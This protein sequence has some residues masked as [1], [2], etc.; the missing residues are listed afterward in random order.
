MVL[1]NIKQIFKNYTTTSIWP[2]IEQLI[3]QAHGIFLQILSHYSACVTFGEFYPLIA[4]LLSHV[5]VHILLYSLDN[6]YNIIP[7]F[8]IKGFVFLS[9]FIF[10]AICRSLEGCNIVAS[11]VMVGDTYVSI[12][13]VIGTTTSY[14][15]Y[16]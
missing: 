9:P 11:E 4:M 15:H 3:I 14:R 13:I 6:S 16:D 12:L 7:Y 2:H 8:Y 1:Q 5:V 10:I